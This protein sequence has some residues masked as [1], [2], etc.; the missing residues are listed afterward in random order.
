MRALTVEEAQALR[1]GLQ[2]WQ[3]TKDAQGRQ[4]PQD[5]LDV[6]DIMLATG[7]R[8]GEALGI[9]WSDVDLSATPATVTINGTLVYVKG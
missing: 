4:R 7:C 3:Q 2:Q 5:L 6:V 8:I 9:R 1:A